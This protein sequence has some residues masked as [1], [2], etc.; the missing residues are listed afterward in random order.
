[1]IDLSGFRGQKIAVMGL[2]K[3]GLSAALS[4]MQSGV[5]VWAWDDT[6][7]SRIHAESLGI[8]VVDLTMAPFH[9]LSF[10]I[11]SPGIPHTHRCWFHLS[12]SISLSPNYL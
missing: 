7:A 6:E 10:I 12:D 3:T 11:W 4:L 8:L 5:G 2:G 9:D 1:M